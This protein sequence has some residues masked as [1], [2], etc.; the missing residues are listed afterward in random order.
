MAKPLVCEQ[1]L[2]PF[3]NMRAEKTLV[4]ITNLTVVCTECGHTT[5]LN[6]EYA[7]D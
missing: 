2:K 1:C 4:T 7:S 6:G 5:I 3:E